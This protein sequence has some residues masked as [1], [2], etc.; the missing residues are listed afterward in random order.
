MCMVRRNV[1][2][3]SPTEKWS[4]ADYHHFVA[5][6]RCMARANKWSAVGLRLEEI[7]T[8]VAED[9]PNKR[10]FLRKALKLPPPE[11]DLSPEGLILSQQEIDSGSILQ[12]NTGPM[13]RIIDTVHFVEKD[14][15][16]L[17]QIADACAFHF[18]PLFLRA[19]EWCRM[20]GSNAG[21]QLKLERMAG[22]SSDYTFSFDPSHAYPQ[23]RA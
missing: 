10:S 16:P 20:A 9:V 3:P 2:E 8:V 6:R 13:D 22:P 4:T 23:K 1:C 18:P 12:T 14:D 11:W 17:L 19:R 7:A 5:F 15:G 21:E